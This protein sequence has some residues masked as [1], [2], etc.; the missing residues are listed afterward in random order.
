M[1]VL[2]SGNEAISRGAYEANVT[3]ATAYPGTP[4][5][6]ILETMKKYP[7]IKAQWAPNEKVALEVAIG[8]SLGGA[9]S[10][11]AMKHVGLNVAADPFLTLSYTGVGGGLV[12]VSADDPGLHSSQ[13]EQDNRHYARLA[14]VPILEPSN[15]QEAK[16]YVG[17]A[18][19]LSEEFE[20]PV[21]LRTTTRISH[22][23]S[24]VEL[25][26]H[27]WSSR[28][29][30]EKDPT[31]WVMVPAHAKFRHL[32]VEA[33]LEDLAEWI[34]KSKLNTYDFNDRSIGIITSGVS[35]QYVKEALPEASILKLG[36]TYPLC[37]KQIRIFA[38][39]VEKVYVVEEL[40]PFLEEQIRALG[41][42]VTGKEIIPKTGELST[43]IVRKAFYPTD[44][45]L[46]GNHPKPLAKRPPV[47]CA[48]CPHRASIYGL[49][50]LGVKVTGDIGCY[51]L[52]ALPPIAGIDSCVCMGAS[53]GMAE[54]L[55][56]ADP[57]Y[58]GNTVAVIGDSTFLHSGI[59]G[60]LDAVYNQAKITVVILDNRT[61]AM[62]GH[63]DHPGTGVTL[64]GERTK[65][66]NLS[67]LVEALGVEHVAVVDPLN[68]EKFKA[69]VEEALA[70]D[71]PSVVISRHPCILKVRK[72][73][74]PYYIDPAQC[75]GC[76]SCIQIGCPAIS[77]AGCH[78]A[79][80]QTACIGCALCVQI[81]PE[82]AIK[83][84]GEAS[85]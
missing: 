5:T 71:G 17:I 8:A 20:T 70:F 43:D 34:W 38:N 6:E 60:L 51:T 40:D 27:R 55:T 61:T 2:L 33:R 76:N 80:N 24:L 53:I 42:E 68:Q 77:V 74:D 14:K 32:F 67:K 39:E 56:L 85:A 19:K 11:V 35:Y 66:V 3:V 28:V 37:E 78:N 23:K 1:K 36:I 83:K 13:N 26:E 48:G 84:V 64:H 31:K 9:R 47:L 15:S 49:K 59:Q 10:L 7:E 82:G 41:I 44:Y 4:S 22:S 52:G 25:G 75:T 45:E 79:I 72:S 30:Y 62:T 65:A 54:G 29:P 16:D 73:R 57:N 50:R 69:M 18:L 12:L 81:C 63:Q 46:F 21:M 58:A